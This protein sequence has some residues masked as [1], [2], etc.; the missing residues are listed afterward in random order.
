MY[1]YASTHVQ[2]ADCH[3]SSSSSFHLD[4]FWIYKLSALFRV[5]EARINTLSRS[6]TVK[7]TRA[8]SSFAASKKLTFR[9]CFHHFLHYLK[10]ALPHFLKTS[11]S[12]TIEAFVP[13]CRN[14]IPNFLLFHSCNHKTSGIL[15]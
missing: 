6:V 9:F 15:L 11:V 3:V 12:A 7:A 10:S 14:H 13:P 2:F 5:I 1:N 4:L 8:S